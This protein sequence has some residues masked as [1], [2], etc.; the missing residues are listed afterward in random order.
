MEMT[1]IYTIIGF[2]LAGYSVIANDSIQTLG[3]LSTKNKNG[4]NGTHLQALHH[5]YWSLQL[6]GA[7]T[8]TMEIYLMED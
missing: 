3:T 8:A 5:L 6:L 7:G 2:A 1:L 4:S